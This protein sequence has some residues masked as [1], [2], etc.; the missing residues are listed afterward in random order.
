MKITHYT[1]EHSSTRTAREDHLQH[2]GTWQYEATSEFPFGAEAFISDTLE[3][4]AREA[5]GLAVWDFDV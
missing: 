4:G 2:M 5:K 3:Q 1:R